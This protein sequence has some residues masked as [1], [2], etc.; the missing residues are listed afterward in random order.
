[1]H[2]SIDDK[3]RIGEKKPRGE[4]SKYI[5]S[6]E[7]TK[8]YRRTVDEF[9]Q[10]CK[11]NRIKVKDLSQITQEHVQGFFNSRKE[12]SSYTLSRELSALN[13]IL[14]TSYTKR[15]FGIPDR[16]L[17]RITNNRGL[18]SY[19]GSHRESQKPILAFVHA[20]GIRRESISHISSKDAIKD[21]RGL[22]I[23]FN[24][25]EKGGR[26]RNAPVLLSERERITEF[27]NS[28]NPNE[29]F[30]PKGIAQNTN[31]HWERRAYA[32]ESYNQLLEAKQ[33]GID[34]YNGYKELFINQERQEIACSRYKN[35]VVHGYQKQEMSEVSQFLGHNRID[36]IYQ[37]YLK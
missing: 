12:Y 19:D 15:D 35:D 3:L 36:I 33:N 7:T 24:V 29:P 27:V 1:M 23:G 8:T 26:E 13:K 25:V 32:Q 11:D 5:H 18:S 4:Q 6:I 14:E 17:S 28:K 20:T 31:P 30:F 9:S 22:V 34:Y 2:K 10:Y 16:S 37:S 21:A